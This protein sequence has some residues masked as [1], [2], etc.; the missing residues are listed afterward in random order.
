MIE[1]NL[2]L[3][4]ATWCGH[5]NNFFPKD[6]YD[7]NRT[8]TWQYVKSNIKTKF[9]EYVSHYKINKQYKFLDC[10]ECEQKEYKNQ[11]GGVNGFPT[12]RVAFNDTEHGKRS[13]YDHPY[14]RTLDSIFDTT[15]ESFFDFTGLSKQ[16]KITQSG[17]QH[18]IINK[19]R[20]KY[21]KYKQLY[22]NLLNSINHT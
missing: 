6:N 9:D 13:V 20:N 19:Y 12:I 5:C 18:T 4:Y 2:V 11:F 17:G 14:K 3:I 21:H 15:I 7:P 1:I 8:D 16:K 22:V 10:I